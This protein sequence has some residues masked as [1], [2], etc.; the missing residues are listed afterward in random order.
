[1]AS[2]LERGGRK[3]VGRKAFNSRDGAMA[4]ASSWLVIAPMEAL[5]PAM[6]RH[7]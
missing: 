2:H 7:R 1:M 4:H 3:H 6:E 5:E